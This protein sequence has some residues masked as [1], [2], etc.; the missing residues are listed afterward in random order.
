MSAPRRASRNAIHAL[1]IS[2]ARVPRP[3]RPRVPDNPVFTAAGSVWALL[4]GMGLLLLGNGLQGSLL[5]VRATD[6]AF[7]STVTGLVMSGYFVGFL[8]GSRLAPPSIRRVGHLRV[9][10]AIA[11][12]ASI[13]ILVQGLVVTP[14]AWIL[15]RVVTGFCLATAY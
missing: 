7:G 5:G 1:R 13:A 14:L 2:A 3:P 6:E 4:L 9:F 8:L 12:M 10:A 15:M 11:S